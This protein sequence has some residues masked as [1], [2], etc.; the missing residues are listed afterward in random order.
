MQT[1]YSQFCLYLNLLVHIHQTFL[2]ACQDNHQ[3]GL[4]LI[5]MTFSL[6]LSHSALLPSLL[7]IVWITALLSHLEVSS[8][9]RHQ[10]S[11]IYGSNLKLSVTVSRRQNKKKCGTQERICLL[12]PR[13]TLSIISWFLISWILVAKHKY[14]R[15]TFSKTWLKMIKDLC[16]VNEMSS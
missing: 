2:L 14:R 6:L 11:T 3:L 5:F 1:S 15:R 16:P 7:D 9:I 10:E 13:I 4:P 12:K 8:G